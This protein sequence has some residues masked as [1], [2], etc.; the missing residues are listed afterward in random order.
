MPDDKKEEGRPIYMGK[1][2]VQV[3]R[4]LKQIGTLNQTVQKMMS[5]IK[6]FPLT[7]GAKQEE[8][9]KELRQQVDQ[10]IDQETNRLVSSTAGATGKDIAL[11][12]NNLFTKTNGDKTPISLRGMLQNQTLEELMNDPNGQ[13][14]LIMSNRYKNINCL[15]ED[16]RLV[17]DQVS[18]L[19][20][21]IDTFRDGIVNADNLISDL[22]R[23][24]TFKNISE[25]STDH[26][27]LMQ[28]VKNME[29]ETHIKDRL[30]KIIIPE[31][32]RY[33]NFYVFTQPYADLFA[34]FKAMDDKY[35]LKGR[36]SY[37]PSMML[38][39]S[40]S[41]QPTDAD[42]NEIKSVYE[43]FKPEFDRVADTKGLAKFSKDRV[44]EAAFSDMIESYCKEAFTV[45]NDP[46]VPLLESAE[47]SALANPSMRESIMKAM[48]Q[49]KTSH[50]WNPIKSGSSEP[51]KYSDGVLNMRNIDTKDA[52][53]RYKKD[54]GDINGVYIKLYDPRRCIPIYLMDYC[55]GYY[56][57]YEV[58]PAG[59]N[60]T[61]NSVHNISRNT[62]LFRDDK[63]KEFEARFIGLISDRI[64]R[65]I[66][67]PFLKQNAQ[68]K[69]LIANAISYNNFYE[70][71][72]RVQFVPNNYMTHF[73]INQSYDDHLGVSVLYRSLFYAMLYLMMLLYTILIKVTRG[74]D[75]RMFLIKGNGVNKDI[76]GKMNRII[77]DFKQKQISYNDFGSVRGILSKVGQGKDIGVP[78]GANNERAFDIEQLPGV[79]V[80]MDNDLM[81]LLRKA[82]ISTTGCP[83]A[84][85]N[86]L[87]EVDFAKQIQ[88]LHSKF[89]T[90]CIAY[91]EETEVAC[92]ELY[93]K[94][95]SYGQY[96]IS[97]DQLEKFEFHWSR[98]KM[99]NNQNM[100]DLIGSSDQFAEFITK[101]FVGENNTND[102]RVKDKIYS[103]IIKNY[104]MQGVVDWDKIE[105]DLIPYMLELRA[106]LRVEDQSKIEAEE[107][108]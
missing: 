77:S 58:D 24:L 81:Q 75:L 67:K 22:S 6:A 48:K 15:Y 53:E 90:R 86:Y 3:K 14:E 30:K 80:D 36:P 89:V 66:D 31:T 107:N 74:S 7:R 59:E 10:V 83:S 39:E 93:R 29:D 82:M 87:D 11:F 68:F 96:D 51:K 108:Q 78:V 49:K 79:Q 45:I 88:M 98:P 71:A 97:D 76:S 19:A 25:N 105:Q 70:K 35:Q 65:S 50:D 38:R 72:F 28:V 32:L 57:L 84:M 62:M 17:T 12:L 34:K 21:V 63:K 47:I 100:G 9:L 8:Q 41:Y 26:S 103:Y 37:N 44:S 27:N 1:D 99:L 40:F 13:Y 5:Q 61:L 23:T 2:Q 92:T 60:N 20:E 43:S 33:G 56:I 46:E 52:E 18:E 85:I 64:C 95:L 69:E 4:S 91:Q 42:K 55:I 54:F 94:I 104:L 73:C 102:P 101:V 16:I 106:Q